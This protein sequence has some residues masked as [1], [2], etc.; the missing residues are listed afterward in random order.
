MITEPAP[1]G[2]DS[3]VTRLDRANDH[4]PGRYI[5]V[6]SKFART[7]IDEGLPREAEEAYSL[8]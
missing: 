7:H 4:P 2:L 3:T 1:E 6:G 8:P 5:F